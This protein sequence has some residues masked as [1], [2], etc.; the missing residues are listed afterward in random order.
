MNAPA[1]ERLRDALINVAN[2]PII[3]LAKLSTAVGANKHQSSSSPLV[4]APLPEAFDVSPLTHTL[5]RFATA[6]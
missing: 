1:R 4:T 3:F 5:T 6:P 2:A